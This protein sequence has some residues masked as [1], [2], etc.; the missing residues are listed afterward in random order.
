MSPREYLIPLAVGQV[1][2]LV[3]I[4]VRRGVRS[5]AHS[6]HNSHIIQYTVNLKILIGFF[7]LSWLLMLSA[8]LF[9]PMRVGDG[10]IACAMVITFF[11]AISLFTAEIFWVRVTY[12]DFGITT[13]SPYKRNRVVP[14]SDVARVRFGFAQYVIE[15]SD[16]GRFG[17]SVY[18]DGIA[19]WLAELERRGIL[20]IKRPSVGRR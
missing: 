8:A 9:L 16:Q 10:R 11:A 12:D 3:L 19:S 18:M 20:V 2:S 15:T 4:W 13:R 5:E 6:N 7:W 17:C 1:V 14:W